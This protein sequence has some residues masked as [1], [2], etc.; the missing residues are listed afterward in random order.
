M[1]QWPLM[2]IYLVRIPCHSPW[3]QRLLMALSQ[4]EAMRCVADLDD[5]ME[6]DEAK[7]HEQGD[8]YIIKFRKVSG[9]NKDGESHIK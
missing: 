7:N 5:Y 2:R 6:S 8:E 4:V 1:I 9:N 3:P